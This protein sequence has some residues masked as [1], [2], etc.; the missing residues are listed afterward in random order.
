[1]ATDVNARTSL[2]ASIGVLIELRDA[3]DALT[4]EGVEALARL[5][6]HVAG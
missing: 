3:L 4:C 5:D 6:V 1:L 2:D